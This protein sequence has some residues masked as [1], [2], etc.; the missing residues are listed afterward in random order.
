V[1]DSTHTAYTLEGLL[2][3]LAGQEALPHSLAQQIE[4]SITRGL[5]FL[6]QDL[7]GKRG[8][9]EKVWILSKAELKAMHVRASKTKTWP[10]RRTADGTYVVL[11]P[12]E[13]RLWSLGELLTLHACAKR[14]GRRGLT[15]LARILER[16]EGL[17]TEAGRF[18]YRCD[19]ARTFV[20]HEAHV[21]AGLVDLAVKPSAQ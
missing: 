2:R 14:A 6:D 12:E 17:S 4:G 21:F 3:I 19:D 9:R 20:R 8:L 11:H 5:T 15:N 18:R 7:C 10:Q 1:V 16:V 13:P